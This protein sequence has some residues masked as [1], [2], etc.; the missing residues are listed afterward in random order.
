MDDSTVYLFS[1]LWGAT[2]FSV[3]RGLFLGIFLYEKGVS[4]LSQFFRARNVAYF[5]PYES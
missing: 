4:S 1:E 5:E 2:G 3:A